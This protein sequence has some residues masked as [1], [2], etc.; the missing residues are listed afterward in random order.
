[1]VWNT[2][3]PI[4]DSALYAFPNWTPATIATLT[5]WGPI[6]FVVMVLPVS[7]L[8]SKYGLRPVTVTMTGMCVVGHI[9]RILPLD[10]VQF[11]WLVAI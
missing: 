4:S 8:I 2:W 6:S 7:W 9:L 5:N 10:P 11:T 3:G 1:M